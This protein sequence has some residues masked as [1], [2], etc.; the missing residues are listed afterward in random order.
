MTKTQ[1]IETQYQGYRFRS[2][3]EA[4]WA[5]YFNALELKWE[6]EIEGYK[7]SNNSYYLPDFWFPELECFAEVKPKT[8]SKQEFDKC[9]LLEF[10][11]ILLDGQVSN[12]RQSGV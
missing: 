8:F 6:Y 9:A 5:V 11:T 2:R 3:T 4:R 7:L 12:P 10:P 1:A